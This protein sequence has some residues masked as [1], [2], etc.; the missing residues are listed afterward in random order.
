ME[1]YLIWSPPYIHEYFI[2]GLFV[3][4]LSG[5]A[6]DFLICH[7]APTAYAVL[8]L[9]QVHPSAHPSSTHH[10]PSVIHHPSVLPSFIHLSIQSPT[11]IHP[12]ILY[13]SILPLTAHLSIIHSSSITCSIIHQLC[14]HPSVQPSILLLRSYSLIQALFL[15]L[16]PA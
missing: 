16:T 15:A 12:S 5:P 10:H 4:L 3:L 11:I 7:L 14:I 9:P 13:Q 8:S 1:V 2:G 6:P